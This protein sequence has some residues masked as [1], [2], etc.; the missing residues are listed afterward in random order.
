MAG[1]YR[2]GA[3]RSPGHGTPAIGAPVTFEGSILRVNNNGTYDIAV[4]DATQMKDVAVTVSA[5][6]PPSLSSSSTPSSSGGRRHP[7]RADRLGAAATGEASTRTGR[8]GRGN[9]THAGHASVPSLVTS[10]AT[11]SHSA[12]VSS[13][14]TPQSK[15]R[16]SH[17]SRPGSAPMARRPGGG[18]GGGGGGG[19]GGGGVDRRN[20][21]PLSPL[22]AT[23]GQTTRTKLP[24]GRLPSG[25]QPWP[26]ARH[27]QHHSGGDFTVSEHE[28]HAA[29]HADMAE[30]E[31]CVMVEHCTDCERCVCS[32]CTA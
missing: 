25:H 24:L 26:P 8:G 11:S 2:G 18:G 29:I 19:S 23:A 16:S 27:Q 14:R 10:S 15:G 31:V 17:Q 22:S 6:F 28:K 9:T 5:I 20:G 32:M 13:L 12:S 3:L 1:S 21:P 4:H 7:G 30:G